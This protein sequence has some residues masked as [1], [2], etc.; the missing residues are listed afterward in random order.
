MADHVLLKREFEQARDQQYRISRSVDDSMTCYGKSLYLCNR[1]EAYSYQSRLIVAEISWKSVFDCLRELDP[2]LS[3][4]IDALREP[5][6]SDFGLHIYSQVLVDDD[7]KTADPTWEYEL[8][9]PFPFIEW[10]GTKNSQLAVPVKTVYTP[11]ESSRILST[12]DAMRRIA[13]SN[14]NQLFYS[15]F[16]DLLQCVRLRNLEAA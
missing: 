16:N 12:I 5:S 2:S 7:W 10:D 6:N 11:E 14:S 13:P 15:R 9:P 1:L 8:S 3:T 4:A